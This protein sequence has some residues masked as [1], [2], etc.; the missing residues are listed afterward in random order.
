MS[1]N[2]LIELKKKSSLRDCG[3]CIVCCV[4]P[5]IP[6]LNK[7]G[8]EHC[9]NLTLPG[10]EEENKRY[11]TG[12]SICGNCKIYDSKEKPLCCSEYNC[13]WRMGYGDEGDRP[14]KVFMLFDRSHNIENA[15]EAKPLKEYQENTP[16]GEAVIERMS[17]SYNT[18]VIVLNFY[19]KKIQRI[20]GQGLK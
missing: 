4:Y 8:M 3:D 11:Y 16:E 10:P 1:K 13:A 7:R 14:D 15:I 5:R 12:N 6:E 17:K 19:E 18:P 2:Q 20:A 9:S